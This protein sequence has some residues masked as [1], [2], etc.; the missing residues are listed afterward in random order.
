MKRTREAAAILAAVVLCALA[1][2][3]P[4]AAVPAAGAKVPAATSTLKIDV[5]SNRA[6]LISEGDALVQIEVPSG[7]DPARCGWTSAGE[8]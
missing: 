5:L 4:S 8:M 3:L 6:D 2:M 7:V 1:A